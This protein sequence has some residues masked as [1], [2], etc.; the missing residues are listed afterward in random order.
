MSLEREM[1]LHADEELLVPNN[2][3]QDV[4]QPHV[5]DHG[6]EENTHIE[7]STRNGKRSTTEADILRIDATK[8]VGAPTSLS[9]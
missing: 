9:R 3:P 8:N 2:E 7:S 5:E 1:Y 4:E 6:M